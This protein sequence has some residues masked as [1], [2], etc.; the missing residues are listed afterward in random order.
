MA[1]E[2]DT[3][4]KSV[5]RSPADR[6]RRGLRLRT[7]AARMAGVGLRRFMQRG[8]W[9]A[10]VLLLAV[11]VHGWWASRS[12]TMPGML[13]QGFRQAQTAISID[14][15]KQDGFRLDY[16]TPVLGKPWSI[17]LE[18]P[19][20]QWMAARLSAATGMPVVVA[21]RWVSLM[22]FYL[23]LPALL[24][25]LRAAGLRWNAACC[26]LLPVLASPVYLFY[27]RTVL[28]ESTAFACSAWFLA[29]ALRH[30]SDEGAGWQVGAWIAG[31]LAVL[32]KVTTWAAFAVPWALVV[33]WTWWRTGTGRRRATGPTLRR[34]LLMV[35]PILAVAEGWIWTADRI[36]AHNPLAH[37]LLSKNLIGFTFGPLGERMSPE[38]W[39]RLF[40]FWTQGIMPWW[41]LGAVMVGWLLVAPRWR[42]LITAAMAGFIVVQLVFAN[43]YFVHDHYYY[44][45]GVFLALAA[46]LVVCGLWEAGGARRWLSAALL[47]A[48]LI[49]Q[50][51]AYATHYYRIQI[52]INLGDDGLTSAIRDLTKPNDVLVIQGDDWEPEIPF[53]SGRRALMIPDGQM[54]L[55][56]RVVA[57]GIAALRGEH[58]PLVLF[59]NKARDHKDWIA[60]RIIDFRLHPVPLFTHE[61]NAVIYAGEDVYLGYQVVLMSDHYA[62]VT[63]NGE[64]PIKASLEVQPLGAAHFSNV[65]GDMSPTPE[66]GVLP[67]GLWF[68][69]EGPRHIF[70][71]H[72]P[73]ELFFPIPAGATRVEIIY[74]VYE[75]AYEQPGYD[76]VQFVVE[77]HPPDGAARTLL[78][79]WMG[80]NLPVDRRGS[81]TQVLPLPAG[82]RGEVV[83]RTLPGP[84]N[85]GAFDWALIERLSIH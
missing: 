68:L 70:M 15:M 39:A 6:R 7:K 22:A 52:T 74:R 14:A 65:F 19:L 36:K 12:W 78:D 34:F 56:P 53:Y 85:N 62:G 2:G 79:D 48:L 67:F 47:P 24:L 41:G 21:G 30:H 61:P 9:G 3:R 84:Q 55:A 45:C 40:A 16:A 80:P 33:A 8:G 57:Q 46:G 28:M 83:V 13:G 76:G 17:P 50:A 4:V 54:D 20:Y 38:F 25:M 51:H 23:S 77:Y 58:V 1:P 42:W 82:A 44:A 27:S 26:A 5:G 73:T 49:G 59:L 35:V 43:L 71:A 29:C 37:F 31:A 10:V 60:Q 32:V 63:V 69:H 11:A 64:S 72:T 75:R 66:R 81:R 18:F